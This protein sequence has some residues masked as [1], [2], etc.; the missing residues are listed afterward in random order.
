MKL[1]P[2]PRDDRLPSSAA[3]GIYIAYH[4]KTSARFKSP[5]RFFS[6]KQVRMSSARTFKKK[7]LRFSLTRNFL[8]FPP[9]KVC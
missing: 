7:F 2:K 1:F 5:L 8:Y 3:K 6:L 9:C 4:S